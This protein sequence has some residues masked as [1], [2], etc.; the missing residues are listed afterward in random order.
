MELKWCQLDEI[1]M[2]KIMGWHCEEL[3]DNRCCI[4]ISSLSL[5]P[6]VWSESVFHRSDQSFIFWPPQ[7]LHKTH[8][9]Q[10]SPVPAALTC[11]DIVLWAILDI[12]YESLRNNSI[13]LSQTK[14]RAGDGLPLE[15]LTRGS[16]SL[17]GS[18]KRSSVVLLTRRQL[19]CMG[20]MLLC[21]CF[22]ILEVMWTLFWPETM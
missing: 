22:I 14:G 17:H 1:T 4:S 9:Q 18:Y 20:F 12:T 10:I 15:E 3:L 13:Y 21:W 8:S 5:S 16:M 11:A 6:P 7:R 19:E 2:F